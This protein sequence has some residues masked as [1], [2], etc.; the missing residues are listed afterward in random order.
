MKRALLLLLLV[1]CAA[2]EVVDY[3][4]PA[5][6]VPEGNV[7]VVLQSPENVSVEINKITLDNI[8][9]EDVPI[10][11]NAVQP[12]LLGTL[13]GE[14]QILNTLNIEFGEVLVAGRKA[15]MPSRTVKI[16]H[17]FTI[18]NQEDTVIVLELLKH[19]STFEANRLVFAP[20]FR[21]Y[22]ISN[23]K[24]TLQSSRQISTTGSRGE[25]LKIGMNEHGVTGPGLTIPR[26]SKIIVDGEN[27]RLGIVTVPEPEVL[28]EK[29]TTT[30]GERPR[31]TKITVISHRMS[32]V[33][34]TAREGQY[35][36]LYFTSFDEVYGIDLEG[37]DLHVDLQPRQSN[38]MT[39]TADKKGTF[40]LRCRNTCVGKEN[41]L[42]GKL[43]VR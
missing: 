32:P 37:Y 14:P 33:K 5:P 9:V 19:E 43:T 26:T 3:G 40:E 8:L 35:V 36:Q 6:I 12:T 4:T 30:L 24:V 15:V 17:P 18:R 34:L 2:P 28:T 11:Y 25:V 16:V 39:F 13:R 27:I 41:R 29:L 7:H 20:V 31:I 10:T 22:E 42:M 1:A 23:A 21:V 38:T